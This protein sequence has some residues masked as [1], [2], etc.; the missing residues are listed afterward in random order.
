MRKGKGFNKAVPPTPCQAPNH[1]SGSKTV[2][3]R[4]DREESVE[5]VAALESCHFLCVSVCAERD[6]QYARYTERSFGDAFSREM[7][8]AEQ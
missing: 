2:K 7:C 8:S 3:G 4:E 1:L 5:I 6:Y